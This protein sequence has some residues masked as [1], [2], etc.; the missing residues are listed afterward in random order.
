MADVTYHVV[1]PFRRDEEGELVAGEAM[2]APSAGA[3]VTRAE[4]LALAGRDGV[5]GTV[6]FSRSGDPA[7]GEFADAIVLKRFGACPAD[8]IVDA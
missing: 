5:C 1:L 2:E 4:R 8:L 7:T 6:A 3:A